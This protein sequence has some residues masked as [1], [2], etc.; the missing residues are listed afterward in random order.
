MIL[1]SLVA[2]WSSVLGLVPASQVAP[3]PAAAKPKRGPRTERL[4]VAQVNEELGDFISL[5]LSPDEPEAN[6]QTLRMARAR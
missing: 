3:A 6:V 4:F 5:C 2:L 1:P